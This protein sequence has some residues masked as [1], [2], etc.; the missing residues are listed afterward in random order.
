[1]DTS[2]A[3]PPFPSLHD[4]MHGMRDMSPGAR[5]P[6]G[7]LTVAR[8]LLSIPVQFLRGAMQ[9]SPTKEPEIQVNTEPGRP[10]N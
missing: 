9:W 1:M 8:I 3:Q 5:D 10:V 7:P 6:P 2:N 4:I